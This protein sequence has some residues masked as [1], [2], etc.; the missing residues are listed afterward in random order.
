[1]ARSNSVRRA[2]PATTERPSAIAP[3]LLRRQQAADYL[4]LSPAALDVLRA[5]GD[6]T[7]VPVPSLRR[8]GEALRIPLYDVRDLD[9]TI[10]RWKVA[11]GP[12]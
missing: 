4:N 11:G 12:R 3:R 1:M 7:P 2:V 9:D 6:V 10:E 5:R 8:E